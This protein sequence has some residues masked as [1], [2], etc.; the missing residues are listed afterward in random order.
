MRNL[1]ISKFLNFKITNNMSHHILLPIACSF[2]FFFIEYNVTSLGVSITDKESIANS[3]I[4]IEIEW[5]PMFLI[6]VLHEAFLLSIP[7]LIP[8]HEGAP[9]LLEFPIRDLA[10]FAGLASVGLH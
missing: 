7:N 3:V 10:S 2:L 1:I 8:V 4:F 6:K 9:V 5:K